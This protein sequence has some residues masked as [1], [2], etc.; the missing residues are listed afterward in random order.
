MRAVSLFS[1]IGVGEARLATS[2]VEVCVA[3]EADPRRA[4]AYSAIY[5]SVEMIQGDITDDNV[6]GAVLSACRRHNVEMIFATPPCQGLSRAAGIPR[7]GDKRN[8]LICSVVDAV[9]NLKPK[10]VFVENVKRLFDV[11]IMGRGRKTKVLNLLNS[12]LGGQYRIVAETLDLK[13]F[14]VPQ[15]RVRALILMTRKDQHAIWQL[16]EKHHRLKDLRTTIGHLPSLDPIVTDISES[17]H[18]KLFPQFRRRQL[19]GA[20]VSPWHKPPAHVL[21]QVVAMMHTPTGRTAFENKSHFPKTKT[22]ER[23]RGYLSTYRRLRWDRPA[24]T[25][26]MDNRKISSQN[27]VHPGHQIERARSGETIYSDARA[28][29]ILELMLT[30]TIPSD[31]PVPATLSDAALRSLIGEGVPP[32]FIEDLIKNLS[33]SHG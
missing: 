4:A 12:E 25:V 24:S 11:E 3:N 31:W 20:E 5:P 26:T 17:E 22:G 23:V 19:E 6:M 27:N 28:L 33:Y 21:R 15:S 14:N 9:A 29:S 8:D 10:Y 16:P 32:L 30:M 7:F 13:E 1:G 2:P 18:A